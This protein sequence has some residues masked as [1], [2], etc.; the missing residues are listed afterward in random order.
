MADTAEVDELAGPVFNVG[1]FPDGTIIK[2]YSNASPDENMWV[3]VDKNGPDSAVLFSELAD[4][5][6]DI[7]WAAEPV[8]ESEGAPWDV[9]GEAPVAAAGDNPDDV[10][11]D[12]DSDDENET[13]DDENDEPDKAMIALIPAESYDPDETPDGVT[14]VPDLSSLNLLADDDITPNPEED[15]AVVASFG[16]G[17]T[18]GELDRDELHVTLKYL[19]EADD[20]D[21]NDREAIERTVADWAASQPGPFVC[22]AF[23]AEP[24]GDNGAVVLMLESETIQGARSQLDENL[25][26][27][28]IQ[29]ENLKDSYPA[30]LPHMTTGYNTE[31]AEDKVGQDV[32]LDRVIVVWGDQVETYTLGEPAN[33][34]PVEA[35]EQRDAPVASAGNL[36]G[37]D[38]PV[39]ETPSNPGAAPDAGTVDEPGLSEAQIDEINLTLDETETR[40]GE[41]EGSL[42]YAMLASVVDEIFAGSDTAVTASASSMAITEGAVM[43]DTTALVPLFAAIAALPDDL[44]P[45]IADRIEKIV[46]RLDALEEQVAQMLMAT[47]QD[48]KLP[49]PAGGDFVDETVAQVADAAHDLS[50]KI[51]VS[52]E[53][54]WKTALT[55]GPPKGVT[56]S[57]FRKYLMA[58]AFALKNPGL[59]PSDWRS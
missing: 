3:W 43:P 8:P 14:Q 59:I 27:L 49:Q 51:P 26:A 54:E 4:E 2:S 9:L 19:H 30:F 31:P 34:E 44:P 33:E 6:P 40:M 45:E 25:H 38:T 36:M 13:S 1:S 12:S 28:N 47:V 52:T 11:D 22:R 46:V 29:T 55:A 37:E 42:A 53:T 7:L 58:Q 35:T 56:Q 17:I 24:L 16:S 23:S 48:E 39:A 21:N 20:W 18:D 15:D 41:I 57:A 50:D 10:D 5:H 32:I